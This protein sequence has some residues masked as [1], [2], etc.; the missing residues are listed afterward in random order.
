M[1]YTSNYLFSSIIL[2]AGSGFYLYKLVKIESEKS[3]EK[4]KKL[5]KHLNHM[6]KSLTIIIVFILIGFLYLITVVNPRP[7]VFE[8][9]MGSLALIHAFRGYFEWKYSVQTNR[10]K[11]SLLTSGFFVFLLGFSVLRSFLF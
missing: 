9:I 5:Y 3:T 4:N 8:F 7:I 10:H 6:E 1:M 11:A 2:L